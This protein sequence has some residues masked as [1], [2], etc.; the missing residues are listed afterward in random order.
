M[1]KI[2]QK[3]ILD[4]AKP[5]R[6]TISGFTLIELLVVVL[7]IGILAAVAL[8]QYTKA[9]EKSRVAEAKVITRALLNAEIAYGLA[10]GETT[11]VL[12]DLD[13]TI[14]G[15]YGT[16]GG[17]KENSS[18]TTQHFVYFLDERICAED[19][20]CAPG[21]D[22]LICGQRIGAGY[23][24]C[25]GGSNYDGGWA[26]NKFWCSSNSSYTEEELCKKAGAVKEGDRWFFQ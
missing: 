15:E 17:G 5:A 3:I 26:Y 19:G 12:S 22:S 16:W 20:G 2:Y 6:R 25:T 1:N 13:I 9:V 10:N 11:E 7:I 4:V 8:P 21:T 14:P 18:L 23:W 24:V